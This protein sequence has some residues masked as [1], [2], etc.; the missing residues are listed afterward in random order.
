MCIGR[1]AVYNAAISALGCWLPHGS[2]YVLVIG[3][4]DNLRG[5][6]HAAGCASWDIRRRRRN[7]ILAALLA[8]D[9]KKKLRL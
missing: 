3:L 6:V 8:A 5:Y 2:W 9:N 4:H 7:G 1:V